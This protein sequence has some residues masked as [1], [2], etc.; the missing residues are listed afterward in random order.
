MIRRIKE[1]PM[2][3]R[4]PLLRATFLTLAVVAAALAQQSNAEPASHTAQGTAAPPAAPPAAPAAR[5]ENSNIDAQLFYQLLIGELELG[6]GEAGT[7]YEVVLDAARK[8][9][10]EN[11]FK[12]ATEIA[13]QAR[14]GDQAVAAARAWRVAFPQSLDA[15]RYLIQL[16]VALNKLDEVGEPLRSMVGA[17]PV[18]QQPAMISALPAYFAR[19]TDRKA[20]AGVIESALV[21]YVKSGPT[22]VS[23]LVATGR[24]WQGAEQPERALE[25]A[26]RAHGVDARAEEPALLALDLLPGTSAAEAIVTG[27]L[28]ARPD[29]NG[30]RL[31]Y[32]RVLGGSQRYTEAVAQLEQVTKAAPRV[33][34]PWLTL[35]ALHLELRQP[36]Q[37]TVALQTFVTLVQNDPDAASVD[38]AHAALGEDEAAPSSDRGL[39]SAWLMLA[40][41]AEQQG[42]FAAAEAWLA[43]V[44]SPQRALDVQS[45]RASILARQGKLPEARA[46]I[47]KAPERGPEDARAKL[48][49][50]VQLLRDARQWNEAFTLL[51]SASQRSP[52]DVDLIYEQS[53]MAE[54][55][56]RMDE[57]E[58]LL[59]RVMALKPDHHHAY[60]ALGFSL[61]E[62]NLRLP[63][64]RTLIQ[65]A[66]QLAPNEPFITD[67]LGWVEYRLGNRAEALRLL[68]R[69]YQARPDPEIAAHLGEVLWVTDNR[70]EARSVWRDARNRDNA[71]DVLIETLAR[72][73]VD[74]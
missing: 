43:K 16:L 45:R 46:L 60:N 10:D 71:N 27:H 47:R 49:A 36:S 65:K 61:A 53:M 9:R 4:T 8:A 52:D 50:E 30:I 54:K 33:A 44:D 40:Q 1:S 22:T 38:A 3:A 2:S 56:D 62:R 39:T 35:G 12:R 74:L 28:A 34:Q 6:A 21:P 5:F 19:T 59:R 72:L 67:S 31:L 41:A 14:A 66:L 24:A 42:Q 70:D 17:T 20:A 58:R 48:M 26:Q 55:L 64:A 73:K 32:A 18:P 13:L 37:A 25:L 63:E 23:A 51:G 57:M 29:N 11:L 68:R 69:A 15:H 7:A